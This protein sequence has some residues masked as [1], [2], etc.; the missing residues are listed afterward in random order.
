VKVNLAKSLLSPKGCLEFAKRFVT[1]FGNCS[2]ISIGELLVSKKN[3]ATMSNLPRKRKIRISD[4][5]SI[6][7]YRHKVSGGLQRRFAALPKRAR[8]MLIVLLSPWGAYPSGS[9]IE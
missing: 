2:P 7:G 5:L 3:F 6:M 8:N 9:L 1:P 4:L